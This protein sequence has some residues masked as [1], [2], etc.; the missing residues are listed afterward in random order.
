MEEIVKIV[1]KGTNGYFDFREQFKDMASL[2][3]NSISYECKPAIENKTTE[4]DEYFYAKWCYKTSSVLFK[5]QF[6]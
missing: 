2:T 4:F 5:T 6:K 1:I 3:K